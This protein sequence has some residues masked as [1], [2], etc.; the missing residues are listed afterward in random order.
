MKQKDI[1]DKE[2]IQEGLHPFFRVEVFDTLASTNEF[3]KDKDSPNGYVC[4]A[5]GQRKGKGRNNRFFHSPKNHGIYLSIVLKPDLDFSQLLK[6]TAL[7]SVA[8]YDA[9]QELYGISSQIKWVNDILIQDKKVAGILCEAIMRKDQTKID[10]FIVGIGINLHSYTF[11]DSLK[12]IAGCIED[13]STKIVSRNDFIRCFLNRF[14][15]YYSTIESNTFI[16]TYRSAS[17]IL[18]KEIKIDQGNKTYVAKAIS[19]DE[20]GY[21]VIE[22]EGQTQILSSGEVSIRKV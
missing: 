3:V 18:G 22:K 4:I 6:I 13:F 20:N 16:S 15:Y 9:I 1:L 14:Y 17:Y 11:P 10:S 21:L 2:N 12:D 7:T 8:C 5:D 19:I